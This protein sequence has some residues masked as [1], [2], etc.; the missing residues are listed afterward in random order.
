MLKQ[1]FC[2]HNYI[3]LE[4]RTSSY[5]TDW[6]TFSDLYMYD[7]VRCVCSKCGKCK[8]IIVKNNKHPLYSEWKKVKED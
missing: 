6:Q 4:R 8:I 5:V 2:K 1:I 3:E 7:D